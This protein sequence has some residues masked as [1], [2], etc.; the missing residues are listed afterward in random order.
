MDRSSMIART[1]ASGN[2]NKCS[3]IALATLVPV[4]I[5]AVPEALCGSPSTPSRASSARSVHPLGGS[6]PRPA[7][8]ARTVRAP[9]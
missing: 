5:V 3:P 2:A 6:A 1:R 9:P 8:G 7:S 4:R